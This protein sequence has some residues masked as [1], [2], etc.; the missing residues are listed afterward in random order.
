MN[1]VS[2]PPSSSSIE[3]SELQ[4]RA[5]LGE[6]AQLS[7][8]DLPP[9]E[10]HAEFLRRV[11]AALDAV[12]GGVWIVEGNSLSLAYQINFKELRLHDGDA[13]KHAEQ[14]A[15]LLDRLLHSSDAGTLLLPHSGT[16][17]AGTVGGNEIG[18][19]TEYLLIFCP[20]RTEL[21]N[22]GLVEII[23]RPDAPP[24]VQ[25]SFVQFLAQTC[26]FATDY[27]KNRQ[28]R[29]FGERQHLW[30]TLEE[31]TRTIHQNLDPK[32]AAYT[33]ANEGRRLI[34]CD[35]VSVALRNG[36]VC[37]IT[38]VS[39]QDTVNKRA[40]T[41]RLLGKLATA[42][43]KAG[44]P[45]IYTG[46]TSDFPP[47]IERAIEKYVDES[48]SKM[49]TVYP[50]FHRKKEENEEQ[51]QKR[52]KQQQA[53]GVLIVEQ[54]EDNQIT[55][56]TRKRIDIV[57]E[58][59][60]SALGNAR[61]H[62]SIFLLPL[63]KLLGK[64]K[65]LVSG[66]TLPKTIGVA[67]LVVTLIAVLLFMPW[68]FQMHSTG[69]LEPI[70]RHRIYSPLDAE[71]EAL[72]VDHNTRVSGPTVDTEG[73]AWRGDT[74]LKLRS[75]ELEALE[76]QLYGELQEIEE[77]LR[78]LTR[79]LQ[80]QD[81]R[82]SD[83]ERA[84]L[85]GQERRANIQREVVQRKIAVF[86]QLQKPDLYITSPMD[87]VVLSWDL[88]RRLV[89]KRP[90]SRMQYVMEIADLEG[91]WQLELLMPEKRMG[92]IM[93]QKRRQPDIPLRVEFV[94]ANDPD[95]V[96]YYGTVSE[97]HDRAEVRS[98]SGGAGG[99]ASSINTVSIKVALDDPL[100]AS[101]LRP[102]A[103]CSARIDCGKRPLGYVLFYEVIAF[104]RKNILFRWF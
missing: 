103:E 17:G 58:H 48:H 27:Y 77:K 60:G 4:I 10:F 76:I 61:E 73:Q 85:V 57:A 63:W 67:V 14:H 65:K 56:Q 37:T 26:R 68:R 87:G 32:W 55:E 47:Q 74:L 20:I 89:E 104:I 15:R 7:K 62:H 82:L 29:H 30:T 94:L 69:T 6:I 49:I 9:E 13:Q 1:I 21:E 35:R 86:N 59:A 83:A 81:R 95:A 43:L 70:L 75:P 50:L 16:E 97:I 90:I 11:V 93:E 2:A 39:G 3:R 102:G 72:Y 44:E 25:K 98:D 88:K 38:A 99:M 80:D 71:I 64:S 36:N 5:L 18:N 40:T 46:S 92:Y 8:R 12:G 100:P 53:F 79:M 45:I 54:I 28:L 96:K 41:V 34:G 91:L 52:R 24:A 101:L 31:F 42:V 23:H 66:E 78:S 22:V 51:P 33:V 84:E 19:P